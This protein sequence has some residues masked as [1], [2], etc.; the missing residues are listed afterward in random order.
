[1]ALP[2]ELKQ[3]LQRFATAFREARDRGANESDTVMYL[4][5]FFEEVLE[6]DALKGEISKEQSIKDRYCDVALKIDGTVRLLV[7]AKAASQKVL[8]DKH[9]EQAEN[10]AS[11]AGIVWVLLT[12]GIDWKL[13]HLT[14]NEGEGIAHDLA[15]EVN[16]LEELEQNAEAA[17]EKLGLLS[18]DAVEGEELEAFWEQRKV[19]SAGSIIRALFTQDVVT[20]IRRELN[21]SAAARLDVEDV[22]A[23]IRDV[24]SKEA[25][26]EAGEIGIRKTKKRKRR[27]ARGRDDA[28]VV[29]EASPSEA[30]AQVVCEDPVDP[31][32]EEGDPIQP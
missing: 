12:N 5:K 10:Y 23:A 31:S 22:A 17:W 13:Y 4:V 9:I 32:P 18:R 19:L 29:A 24:L 1:M 16:L 11:R 25:L 8:T 14:F 30:E 6:Y 3:Q 15:F 21:R 26:L 20:V 27:A 7:E 28:V 2:K